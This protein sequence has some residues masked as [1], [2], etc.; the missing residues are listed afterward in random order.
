MAVGKEILTKIRSVESTRKITRA[1]EMVASSRM[2][3]AQQNM[4]TV[5]PYAEGMRRLIGHLA[6]AQSEY[7]HPF[8]SGPEQFDRVGFVVV[9]TDRGLC[10]GLNINLF[11]FV[12]NTMREWDQKGVKS[13]FV[14]I[15][16]KANVFFNRIL[17]ADNML[18]ELS[19]LGDKPK[20]ADLI[21]AL[22]GALSAYREGRIGRLFLVENSF[23]NTMSQRPA[24]MQLLPLVPDEATESKPHWDYLYE[25]DV[26][27]LIDGLLMRY[28]E[29]LVYKAVLENIACEMAARMVAMKSAT[30]N[31]GEMIDSLRLVYN[32][33]RQA[34]ITQEISEIVAG[35]AAV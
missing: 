14:M 24:M 18:G 34:A 31:A 22:Q 8:L 25:T 17:S 4:H 5:R 3:R 35:A 16:K 6:C 20:L 9:S 10:G 28:I 32:K 15:G 26:P 13:D 21:G 27:E 33:A 19:D 30:E 23:V 1:M 29:S 2:R 11:K 12:L 7:K